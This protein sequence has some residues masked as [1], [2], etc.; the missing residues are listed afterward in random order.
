MC[1]S[2]LIL[3]S[4]A[5]RLFIPFFSNCGAYGQCCGRGMFSNL[6]IFKSLNFK[7]MG[8]ILVSGK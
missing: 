8:W 1:V 5:L 6:G 4:V 7:N 3:F 2:M